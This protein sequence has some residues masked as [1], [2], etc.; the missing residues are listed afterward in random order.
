MNGFMAFYE[1]VVDEEALGEWRRRREKEKEVAREVARVKRVLVDGRKEGELGLEMPRAGGVGML[2]KAVGVGVGAGVGGLGLGLSLGKGKF[3]SDS[4]V[5]AVLMGLAVGTL[6]GEARKE[7]S[8]ELDIGVGVGEVKEEDEA[9]AVKEEQNSEGLPLDPDSVLP[10]AGPLTPVKAV[11][12]ITTDTEK[13]NQAPQKIENET[14]KEKETQK[15][16]AQLLSPLE[17]GGERV[18]VD[19]G[20]N[21]TANGAVI[22][23]MNVDGKEEDTKA[24]PPTPTP[25]AAQTSTS[26]TP[27][28]KKRAKKGKGG[29]VVNGSVT[30]D[31][32]KE[33]GGKAVLVN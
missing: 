22:A 16:K 25:P 21:T 31:V 14:E 19:I 6:M 7:E 5:E 11:S 23:M 8:E 13:L 33:E 27:P 20:V 4:D 28:E 26:P 2:G 24:R 30:V 29:V 3:G 1:R 32:G 9:E 15:E 10:A 18:R 17:G 12:L